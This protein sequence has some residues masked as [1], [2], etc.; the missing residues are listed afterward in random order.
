[1]PESVIVARGI[2]RSFGKLRAVAGI[3]LDVSR[4]EMF[5]LI[6][7]DG[8]GKTTLIRMLCGILT[9]DGGTAEIL[10]RDLIAGREE[11]KKHIGYLSQRFTLYGDLTVDE[12]ID[13]FARIHRG[14]TARRE[15]LLRFTGLERFR[16]RLADNLSGG[17]KQKLALI[18]TLI[19]QPTILFLDEPTTGVDPVSRRDLWGILQQLNAGGIT[20]VMSTPYLDEAERCSRVAFLHQGAVM[21]T[22]TPD[23]LRAVTGAVAIEVSCDDPRR[24]VKVL[25]TV[26]PNT[27]IFGDR[28][29][30]LVE[31][32]AA[33]RS[34]A[35]AGPAAALAGDDGGDTV[36][37][38][39]RMLRGEGIGG[40]SART[41]RPTLE[42]L[43][44]EMIS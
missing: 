2:S 8:A 26:Y 24:A 23:E 42:D 14:D 37:A 16:A 7:P 34:G 38:I 35:V 18:C 28:V 4:G 17:M 11:N 12:N 39:L 20:I 44:V 13:F 41:V 27:Q 5:G 31:T 6:G 33:G 30:V 29:R 43:F 19:H 22:G 3:D 15:E 9:P 40:V 21:K 36:Q 1:M 32:A 25:G 10:G